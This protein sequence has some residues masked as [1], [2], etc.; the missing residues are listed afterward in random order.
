LSEKDA[1]RPDGG[2]TAR[3]D[4]WADPA[5][6]EGVRRR[7]AAALERFFDA[8]FPYVYN[9]ALRLTGHR[10]AAEDVTQE[11]FLK[12]YRAADRIEPDR[13]PRPWLTTITY[14]AVRDSAR[15][16]SARP[17]DATDPAVI[18]D[19]QAGGR[20]PDEELSRAEA[21]ELVERALRAL[22]EH[23]RAVVILHEYCGISHADIAT[24]MGASHDAVRKR[25]SRALGQMREYIEGLQK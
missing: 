21:S 25:Y 18:G 4:T 10:E 17:E 12:V 16:T 19:R 24:M 22:D 23:H 11:V 1:Q 20:T 14:N 6:L 15:R 9:L 3:P 8:V 13:S 2:A 5:M 7:D